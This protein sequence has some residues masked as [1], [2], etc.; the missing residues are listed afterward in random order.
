MIRTVWA[1]LLHIYQPPGWDE[2]IVRKVARESY[3]PLF[4]ILKKNPQI[5]ITLNINGSLTEQLAQYK[6]NEII[7]NIKLLAGREQIEF[8]GSA[9]YHTV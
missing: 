2:K 5:K 6:L 1:T 3:I 4:R 9:M 7:T 8:T